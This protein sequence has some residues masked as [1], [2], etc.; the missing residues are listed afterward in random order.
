MV[1]PNDW[2]PFCDAID[3]AELASDP[4]FADHKSRGDNL[5]ELY[6]LIRPIIAAQPT[7]WLA[8]RLTARGIM[9]GKVNTY[10]EFLRE[11]QVEATGIMSWLTQPGFPEPV[12][13]PNIPGLPPFESGTPRAHAPRLGEHS[14]AVLREHGYSEAEIA[15]LLEKQ[16]IG[17]PEVREAAE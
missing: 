7:A 8:E 14:V 2:V 16:V 13:M 12:P 17:A 3:Q 11:A 10:E 9:N 1:R 4:R 5:D 6:T 15:H